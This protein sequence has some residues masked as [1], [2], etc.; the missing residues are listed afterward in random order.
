MKSK[1]SIILKAGIVAA[2]GIAA[3]VNY[4]QTHQSN[5]SLAGMSSFARVVDANAEGIL[6][7]C[8][9]VGGS[10]SVTRPNGT[11]GTVTGLQP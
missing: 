9:T 3:L 8:P 5:Q 6:I 7:G 4:S 2:L 11:T 10:C 1:K